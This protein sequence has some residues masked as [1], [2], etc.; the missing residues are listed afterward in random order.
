M[1]RSHA[2]SAALFLI[3]Y[4]IGDV[5]SA[6]LTITGPGT[7]NPGASVT[8]SDGSS[9]TVFWS[10]PAPLGVT[11]IQ[12]TNSSSLLQTAFANSFPN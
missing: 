8:L 10:N 6:G 2:Y 7:S 1:R 4:T 12:G 9:T 3:V 5:A 11:Y